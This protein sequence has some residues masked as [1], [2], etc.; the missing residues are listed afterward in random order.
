MSTDFTS[1]GGTTLTHCSHCNRFSDGW[2]Q[3]YTGEVCPACKLMHA[4]TYLPA[5]L[6]RKDA[7]LT[8]LRERVAKMEGVVVAARE[9]IRDEKW[10]TPFPGCLR[11]PDSAESEREHIAQLNAALA[12][13]DATAG[14][15]VR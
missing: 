5:E 14:E 13:L 4:A 10:Y 8:A 7:Q 9:V 1:P 11:D 2:R 6:A 3:A 12:A 15:A